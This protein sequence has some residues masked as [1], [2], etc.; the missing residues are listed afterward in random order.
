MVYEIHHCEY[1]SATR[2]SVGGEMK[3]LKTGTT[4]KIGNWTDRRLRQHTVPLPDYEF[5]LIPWQ[6][7]K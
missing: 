7:T 3:F 1:V 5:S 4:S 6:S 2:E